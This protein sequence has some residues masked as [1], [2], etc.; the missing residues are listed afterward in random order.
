MGSGSVEERINLP[1]ST[2]MSWRTY[3][4]NHLLV[5]E[6]I[7]KG[8]GSF[9]A[10]C[11]C[12]SEKELEGK[13]NQGTTFHGLPSFRERRSKMPPSASVI[14]STSATVSP[15]AEPSNHTKEEPSTQVSMFRVRTLRR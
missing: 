12:F 11:S 2:M 8:G 1:N 10:F 15:A 5:A 6:S 13:R 14:V 3:W 7:S 9:V 4:L